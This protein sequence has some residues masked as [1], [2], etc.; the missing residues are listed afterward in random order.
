ML[1]LKIKKIMTHSWH[2]KRKIEP[3]LCLRLYA[4]LLTT[5]M[6]ELSILIQTISSPTKI[7]TQTEDSVCCRQIL[8]ETQ[9]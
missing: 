9:I 3:H 4:C 5:P 1:N 6:K 2:Y 7:R 8:I